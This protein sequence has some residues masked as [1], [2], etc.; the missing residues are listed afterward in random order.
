MLYKLML[1]VIQRKKM[2]ANLQLCGRKGHKA[3]CSLS[4]VTFGPEEAYGPGIITCNAIIKNWLSTNSEE[5]E[6]LRWKPITQK[7]N[8][9]LKL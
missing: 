1:L 7:V 2:Q 3:E 5:V 9:C 8:D 4:A 6:I